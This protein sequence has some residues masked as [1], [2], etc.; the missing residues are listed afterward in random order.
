[1]APRATKARTIKIMSGRR[2]RRACGWAGADGRVEDDVVA[3][4]VAVELMLDFLD[5]LWYNGVIGGG[6]PF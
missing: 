1:M 4:G 3:E 5:V 6:L 2:E